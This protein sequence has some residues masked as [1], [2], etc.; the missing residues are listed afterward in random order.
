MKKKSIAL[1]LAICFMCVCF[2]SSCNQEIAIQPPITDEQL[3]SMPLYVLNASY[4]DLIHLPDMP[5]YYWPKLGD[6]EHKTHVEEYDGT[7]IEYYGETFTINSFC[8][9]NS[10]DF[11][12]S[13]YYPDE[14]N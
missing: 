4:N 13:F 1:L 14:K 9:Y 12:S 11:L 6:P 7:E 5:Q 3:R 10:T 2:L 8:Y